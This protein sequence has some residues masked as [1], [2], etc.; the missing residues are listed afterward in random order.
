MSLFTS[1]IK[2]NP[3]SKLNLHFY[4]KPCKH[5]N[6]TSRADNLSMVF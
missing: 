3:I 1:D 2:Q 5:K 6:S 4:T